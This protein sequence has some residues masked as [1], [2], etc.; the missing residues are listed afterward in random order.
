MALFKKQHIMGFV[1]ATLLAT[2][3]APVAAFDI[4]EL[5]MEQLEA[6][7]IEE[8]EALI[9]G[10]SG[11]A[12]VTPE[13]SDDVTDEEV[14]DE[15]VTE[16]EV[17]DE[18]EYDYG[19]DNETGDLYVE[20]NYDIDNETG[21]LYVEENYDINNDVTH[22]P[23]G[24]DDGGINNDV[25]HFPVGPD[26]DYGIN[27]DVAHFPVGPDDYGTNNDVAH[28][29]V[30]DGL[31]DIS[32][33]ISHS[34]EGMSNVIQ[35]IINGKSVE[36]EAYNIN[37]SNYLGLR[38]M[39]NL[40]SSSVD[41]DPITKL[42]VIKSNTGSVDMNNDFSNYVTKYTVANSNMLTISLDNV[43]SHVEAYLI[44]NSNYLGLRDI[45]SLF[46]CSVDYNATTKLITITS[47]IT[48]R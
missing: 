1:A 10:E 23:V 43:G 20:E 8:L 44:D 42:I 15:D 33:Y 30:V 17:T 29:P 5:T 19:M 4:T 45:A 3:V 7:S 11:S 28:F 13:V 34:S 31:P 24:P 36:L 12:V 2:S 39:A 9:L 35:I 6:L 14:T 21:D 27:N 46:N 40:F 26:E 32:G 47:N 41:W 38:N 22:F 18:D 48:P 37:G 25:A 16:D